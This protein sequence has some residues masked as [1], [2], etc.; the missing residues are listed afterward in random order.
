MKQA[1]LL[2]LAI[3]C[4]IIS[5]CAT[6]FTEKTQKVSFRTEPPGANVVAGFANNRR[7]CVTPCVLDIDRR[8][9]QFVVTVSKKGYNDETIPLMPGIEPWVFANILNFGVGSIVDLM[10]NRFM[11]FDQ[12]QF[13]TL[14]RSDGTHVSDNSAKLL[15]NLLKQTKA[16]NEDAAAPK[17]EKKTTESEGSAGSFAM[18]VAAHNAKVRKTPSTHAPVLKTLKKGD[19]V[20]CIKERDEWFLVELQGGETGWCHKS[21]LNKR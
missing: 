12:E 5:G 6:M 13:I 10:N 2:L 21:V 15:Q 14:N 8:G 3:Q 4:L 1:L 19:S 9:D 7:T 18:I 11:K 17:S 16:N 20:T